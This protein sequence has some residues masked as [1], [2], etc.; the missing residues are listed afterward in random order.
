[1]SHKTP[2]HLCP[3]AEDDQPMTTQLDTHANDATDL[4][5]VIITR[6]EAK[7]I[8]RAIES[9]LRS[10]AGR[11]HT[12]ILLVDSASTDETVEIARQYPINI[13]RLPAAWFLSVS[14]GRLIG[15][16]Y[17][18]GELVLHMDGDME[19][20]PQ[21]VD[22]SVSYMTEHPEVGAVGGYWRNIYRKDGQIVGEEDQY[23]DPQG[24]VLEVR[25]VGGAA[26][27]RRAAI[28]KMGGFQPYLKGEEGVYVSMG[29]RYNG[30]KVVRLPCLMSFHY[31]IPP[32]SLAGNQRRLRLGFWQGY[33][34]VL[35][36]Y[37]GTGLFWM[38]I[39]ERGAFIIYLISVLISLIGLLLT[40]FTKNMIYFGG[41]VLIVF[42]VILVF[43]IKKRSLR[44]TLLSL[45]LQ[46]WV[47]YSAV[48]GFFKPLRSSAE[49][50][51]DAE[52]VQVYDHLGGLPVPDSQVLE[53]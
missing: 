49:Y 38:Y 51:T 37:W 36:S 29:I 20:D 2:L 33:G 45:L 1:M 30:Y 53:A 28:Q 9:V 4:S 34:Q 23:R 24:R 3:A 21:W 47:A 32:Q 17:S 11:P 27:Y 14:A 44:K 19:L 52:I 18:R 5:I 42:G 8:A 7:N 50:P 16:H 31:S 48:R 6:N 35:R 10:V 43:V 26:L 22:R 46:S 40:L 13:I 39:K 12:E 25:Y 41:W 15:M